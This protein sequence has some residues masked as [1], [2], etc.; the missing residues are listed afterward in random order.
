MITA[1]SHF[2]G[3]TIHRG[4]SSDQYTPLQEALW[5][6][7]ADMYYADTFGYGRTR[8]PLFN[9]S[10]NMIAFNEWKH[11]FLAAHEQESRRDTM[12]TRAF[13]EGDIPQ[14]LL[15]Y[16]YQ[17]MVSAKANHPVSVYYYSG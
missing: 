12:F 16:L 3:K 14:D 8:K 4:W 11:K 7:Y 13:E 10:I 17:R 15:L 2:P 6:A 1:I 9:C 5:V